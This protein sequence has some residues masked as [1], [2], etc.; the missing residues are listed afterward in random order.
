M[1]TILRKKE[2]KPRQEM[3]MVI[4]AGKPNETAETH[5]HLQTRPLADMHWA[6]IYINQQE[7]SRI[8][9]LC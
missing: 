4:V 1:G 9:V 3:G 2:K 7:V 5:H 8:D 6:N